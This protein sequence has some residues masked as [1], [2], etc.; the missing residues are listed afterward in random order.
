METTSRYVDPATHSYV[1]EAGRYKR[2]PA[3]LGRAHNLVVTVAGSVPDAPQFK[4]RL[5]TVGTMRPGIAGEVEH[6]IDE[7]LAPQVGVLIA[8]YTRRA[9][10]DAG[11]HLMHELTVSGVETAPAEIPLSR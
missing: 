2:I 10:I 8:S 11:N 4:C 9:W 3:Q 5:R 6:M 1:V 7:V